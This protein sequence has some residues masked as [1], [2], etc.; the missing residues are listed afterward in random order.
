MQ[1]PGFDKIAVP[2][3]SILRKKLLT[4]SLNNFLT[5]VAVKKD[6]VK[7]G[8]GGGKTDEINKFSMKSK[9]IKKSAKTRYLK[10]FIF[11]IS[12]ANSVFFI[13]NYPN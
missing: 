4:K 1:Y 6:K 7:S 11:L 3:T 13:K 8:G 9:N 10:K 12:K 5:T 2:F